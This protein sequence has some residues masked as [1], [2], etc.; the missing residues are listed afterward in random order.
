MA[1][2]PGPEQEITINIQEP[3]VHDAIWF[4]AGPALVYGESGSLYAS[5]GWRR[6]ELLI[7]EVAGIS[8]MGVGATYKE[9]P[10]SSFVNWRTEG[11]AFSTW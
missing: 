1:F 8:R 3:F 9:N 6:F 7:K 11:A 5:E 4:G 10:S 2:D